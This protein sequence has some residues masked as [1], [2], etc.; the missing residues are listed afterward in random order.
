MAGG[1]CDVLIAGAGIAGATCA[2]L[3]ARRGMRVVLADR[4]R[5]PR[6]KV[7]GG[8]LDAAAAA[9]LREHGFDPGAHPFSRVRIGVA[10]QRATAAVTPG[11]RVD[12]TAFDAQLVAWAIESGAEFRDAS[13]VRLTDTLLAGVAA[14]VG[15]D[16]IEADLF[17]DASGLSGIDRDG[18]RIA[19]RSRFGVGA[20]GTVD[21]PDLDAE[22]IAMHVG[23]LGYVGVCRLP[24]GRLN[25]A[26]AL[27]PG[28]TRSVGGP[29]RACERVLGEC[30]IDIFLAH[31]DWRG[32]PLLSRSRA[33]SR[34]RVL[35]LGDAGGYVEPFTGEGMGWAIADAI[36][37]SRLIAE[38]GLAP[39]AGVE[40]AF[41][42]WSR[43]SRRARTRRCRAVR[44]I[45][46][47][48]VLTRG[49]IGLLSVPAIGGWLSGQHHGAHA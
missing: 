49:A 11:V 42:R 29:A 39:R 27:D 8:C 5:F 15:P 47:S 28:A 23:S 41:A 3:L 14:A 17:I 9:A 16:H 2:A 10:R 43:R 26:A 22:T 44:A 4:A 36:A 6:A 30:G 13:S 21:F 38:H 40:Q 35:R 45:A 7:C 24:G 48:P 37:A 33:P 32:T 19:K 25:I 18:V 1:R 34:G 12:R 46:R 31:L 20:I